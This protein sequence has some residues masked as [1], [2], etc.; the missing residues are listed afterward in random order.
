MEYHLNKIFDCIRVFSNPQ[1]SFLSLSRKQILIK[2]KISKI[3]DCIRLPIQFILSWKIS[4][5]KKRVL[6]LNYIFLKFWF[7]FNFK[8]IIE[9]EGIQYVWYYCS[10]IFLK[11][12]VFSSSKLIIFLI[13]K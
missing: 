6:L 1:T 12:L 3:K 10:T 4:T 9:K 5:R 2:K 11:I 8:L 7:F 13:F